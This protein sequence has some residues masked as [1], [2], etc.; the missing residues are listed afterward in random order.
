M[1][2]W[3]PHR[4]VNKQRFGRLV[5][6]RRRYRKNYSWW[7]ECVCDCGR[8]IICDVNDLLNKKVTECAVCGLQKIIREEIRELKREA[9]TT[10]VKKQDPR[11]PE[12]RDA[13]NERR[14]VLLAIENI[15]STKT[16]RM[17]G[18]GASVKL[19]REYTKLPKGAVV[20]SLAWLKDK[21]IVYNVNKCGWYVKE[22]PKDNFC[23]KHGRVEFIGGRCLQCINE[24]GR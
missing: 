2:I 3:D 14:L 24:K 10:K 7:W 16:A 23:F 18:I 20:A 4:K 21:G 13:V 5:V 17:Q 22:T 1:P 19:I 15:S 6:R 9:K 11:R 8:K 12:R